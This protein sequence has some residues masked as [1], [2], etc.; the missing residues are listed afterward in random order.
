MCLVSCLGL[1]PKTPRVK[2]LG[3]LLFG[4]QALCV[5]PV[6]AGDC[7]PAGKGELVQV[8]RVYDG[9]T[10]K[11]QDGRHVRV[12]GVN[13][14][15]VDHGNERSGQAL[16][17]ESQ[18]AAE[19]FWRANR[20]ARLFYDVQRVDRY[21]RTLAHVYDAKGNS[22][23]AHLLRKGLGFHAAIPPNLSLQ[24]CLVGQE[25][26]ARKSAVGVWRHRAW[27]AKAAAG[28]TLE[29]TGFQRITGRVVSVRKAQSVWLELDGPVVIK[30]T[31]TDLGNFPVRNW[32]LW[33]GKRV[34]VRGWVSL[35]S[36][37]KSAH[38]KA[39][40]K[41]S[42]K[43]SAKAPLPPLLIQPRIDSSLELLAQ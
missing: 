14:P 20:S 25:L 6:S 28:L 11:L 31:P 24:E 40:A 41:V 29:D 26:L 42:M 19:E 3:V 36:D 43:D 18:L 38:K 21:G 13:A 37:A 7:M 9:D 4:F 12:L 15:E 16:G 30:I 1:K 10:L 27:Q 22:L 32:S 34:E 17:R 5:V 33:E 8:E 35:R 39:S 23:A 2:A